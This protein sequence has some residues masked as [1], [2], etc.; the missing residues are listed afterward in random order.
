[1]GSRIAAR[2][3]RMRRQALAA[4]L[5]AATVALT[6]TATTARALTLATV[7]VKVRGRV[8]DAKT[9]KAVAGAM[10]FVREWRA[11]CDSEG[12]FSITVPAGV[13]S[14]EAAADTYQSAARRIDACAQCQL[15]VEVV[16]IPTHL[17]KE[18]VDVSA[19]VN[20]GSD[21]AATTPVRPAEVL[22]AAGAFENVFRVLHTLPGVTNTG[23]WSSRLSVRGGGPDQNMTVMDG[24]EIHNPYRLYG[25]VSAFNPETIAG[26]ELS[27]GAFSAKYGDRL[28]SILTIDNRNGKESTL[29]T[30]SIGLSATDGNAIMEGRLPGRRGSWLVT[31][32]RTWYDLIA[33]RF[34]DDELPA[35]NDL[36]GKVSLNLTRGS[37]L[38]LFGLRSRER[39]NMSFTEDFESGVMSSRALND[40]AAATLLIPLGNRGVSRTIGAFYDNTDDLELDG[41]F[42]SDIRRSNAPYDDLAYSFDN[43]AGSL[44]RKVRDRSVRQELTY[45]PSKRHVLETGFELHDIETSE[46][47][48]LTLQNRPN[49]GLWRYDLS[50]DASRSHER[51]GAWLV[52]K[53]RLAG[54]LDVE[55]GLRYDRSNMND[56]D[57]LTPRLSLTVRP[58]ART[59]LRAAYGEHTQSP[60]YEKLFQA[61]YII[62]LSEAGRLKLDNERARHAIVGIERDLGPGLSARVEGFYKR[63]DRLIV[64]R[65]ETA[66][67][68]RSRV[69]L[70]DFP[71]GLSASVPRYSMITQY[72]LNDGRGRAYGLDVFLA[73]RAVSSSTRLSGWLAY[74]YTSANRQA[75]GRTYPFE[76]EQP[77]ALSAVAN[78]RASQ[79]L[80]ISLT[81]RF[82]SGFPKTAPAGLNVAGVLDSSDADGDGITGEVIPERDREGR[83][84][85]TID[86]GSVDNRNRSR[87][88][89]YGRLD[90]RTTFVPRWGK[91]RWRLYVDVINLLNRNNSP[92]LEGLEY[93]PDAEL[94]RV[95]TKREGGFPFLPSFGVHVRF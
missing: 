12:R 82:T 28:S 70:Y 51:Y 72:P 79:R 37:S 58:S 6:L 93:A 19:S 66:E 57:E 88:P 60:G 80:E 71:A 94:P 26:F 55:A 24:I 48:R 67:E 38:T 33:E 8:V 47:L 68:T 31:G 45:S 32:R 44:A 22:N 59:R 91:G 49:E 90:L 83:L 42:R 10:V 18:S 92:V 69:A 81:G 1:M 39:S 46:R 63:F 41:S 27:T 87:F 86:Y 5:A 7:D 75:Y 43:L 25:L 34:T 73:R 76:Y 65:L 54:W 17:F 16:L 14:L 78:F 23:E 56:I 4:G 52:D 21:L 74:T 9:Q 61:D 36:Q 29:A 95:V 3:I 40:L 50:H 64:G 77:H 11:L 84:V 62:D 20:G 15:D 13:W 30:G 2:W 53:V 35:F 89:W 85:Y